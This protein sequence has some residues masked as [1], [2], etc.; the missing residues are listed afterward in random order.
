M[1]LGGL[2]ARDEIKRAKV[3]GIEKKTLHLVSCK[4]RVRIPYVISFFVR[5]KILV[6]L[7]FSTISFFAACE[8]SRV[9]IDLGSEGRGRTV[10]LTKMTR[11]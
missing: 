1:D 5:V 8:V 4:T 7:L 11:A 10:A 6:L 9:L 3:H 2:G